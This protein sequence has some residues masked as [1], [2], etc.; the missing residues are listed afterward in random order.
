M[1][2]KVSVTGGSL[3]LTVAEQFPDHRKA[4]AQGERPRRVGVAEI[5]IS[6]TGGFLS[7]PPLTE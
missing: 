1:P 4:F 3:H 7:N 2:G 5:V 6:V